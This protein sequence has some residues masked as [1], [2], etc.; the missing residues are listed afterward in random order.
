LLYTKKTLLQR[1]RTLRRRRGRRRRREEE[2]KE[3]EEEEEKALN[4]DCVASKAP[5]EART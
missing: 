3:E 5:R 2:E 4:I 1:G